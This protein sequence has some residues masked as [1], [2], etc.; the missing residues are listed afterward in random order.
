[1]AAAQQ[2]PSAPRAPQAQQ[3][4]PAAKKGRPEAPAYTKLSRPAGIAILLLLL[5]LSVPVGNGRALRCATPPAFLRQGSVRSLVDERVI[6]AKNALTVAR[7]SNLEAGVYEAVEQAAQALMDARSA[8][9]ISLADQQ[10]A[11][12]VG[13]MVAQA[14]GDAHLTSAMD[15]FGDAGNMLRYE[16]R[17]YNQKAQKALA[18]YEKLPTKALFAQPDLYEGL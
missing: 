8:R 14:K 5:A 12:A 9:E 13:D 16:A 1:M 18:L 3:N 10:L 7:R 15:T 17:E 6:S 4:A 11:A 2:A